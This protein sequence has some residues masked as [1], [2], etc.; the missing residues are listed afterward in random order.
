MARWAEFKRKKAN[1]SY[2]HPYLLTV[3]D[4]IQITLIPRIKEC[5]NKYSPSLLNR[6]RVRKWPGGPSL[7]EG[8][9]IEVVYTS[10]SAQYTTQ[11]KLHLYRESK[12]ARISIPLSSKPSESSKM[13]GWAE[14]RRK[15]ANRSCIHPYLL[16]VYT[17]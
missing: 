15:K 8:K 9:R 3:Y 5:P 2:I 17:T 4:I 6:A 10:I 12:N 16:T 13:A 1:R 14:F 7:K 11:Y